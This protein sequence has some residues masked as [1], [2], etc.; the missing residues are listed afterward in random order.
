[1]Q[2]SLSL[3]SDPW[4]GGGRGG[5]GGG[6]G[7]GGYKNMQSPCCYQV[8]QHVHRHLSQDRE[9]EVLPETIT[10]KYTFNVLFFSTWSISYSSSHSCVMTVFSFLQRE[11][12]TEMLLLSGGHTSTEGWALIKKLI[13]KTYHSCQPRSHWPVWNSLTGYIC[14][15]C[16]RGQGQVSSAR[17]HH[18]KF[19]KTTDLLYISILFIFD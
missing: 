10:W 1:M 9:R 12:Y 5:G 3:S 17:D 16:K 18:R 8:S 11:A 2:F 14:L 13:K 6:G 19:Y 7:G 15:D 4:G